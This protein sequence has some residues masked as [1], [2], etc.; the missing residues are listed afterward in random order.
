[1]NL[2]P[3]RYLNLHSRNTD[4]ALN[5]IRNRSIVKMFLIFPISSIFLIKKCEN[6]GQTSSKLFFRIPLKL[7]TAKQFASHAIQELEIGNPPCLFDCQRTQNS[8]K[9]NHKSQWH[10]HIEPLHFDP[11]IIVLFISSPWY[12]NLWEIISNTSFCKRGPTE[13]KITNKTA[14]IKALDLSA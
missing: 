6:Q 4:T 8:P 1:M 14:R 9:P 7:P 10:A 13:L 11:I 3:K 12:W 2:Q 5:T